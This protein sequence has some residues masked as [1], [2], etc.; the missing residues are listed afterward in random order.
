M[1]PSKL[2]LSEFAN[3]AVAPLPLPPPAE[4][5]PGG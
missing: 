5:K 4:K 3:M 1:P 2:N